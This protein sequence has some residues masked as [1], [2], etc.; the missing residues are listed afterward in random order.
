M[1]G[2]VWGLPGILNDDPVNSTS[3][4]KED[5]RKLQV[6]Q[7]VALRLFLRKPRDTPVTVLLSEAKQLSVHQLVAFHTAAQTY[8]I[9]TNKEPTYHYSRLFSNNP[10]DVA[11]S[12]TNL[13]CRIDVRLSLGRNTFF[14]QAA[15]IWNWLPHRMKTSVNIDTFKRM[16]KPWV[17]RNISVK[18]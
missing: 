13:E 2:G 7:N 16:L 6:L 3:I 12:A 5:M 9:Y 11:R 4:T 14:Y 8:K 1:Y 15:H 18:P 17:M 10:N